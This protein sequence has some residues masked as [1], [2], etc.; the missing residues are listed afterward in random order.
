MPQFQAWLKR[1]D[2]R[3]PV[4]SPVAHLFSANTAPQRRADASQACQLAHLPYT[5]TSLASHLTLGGALCVSVMPL[6][7]LRSL[8]H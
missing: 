6:L 5:R 8:L 1:L 4:G 2:E 3:Y 7:A